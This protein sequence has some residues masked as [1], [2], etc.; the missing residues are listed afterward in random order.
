[1]EKTEQSMKDDDY[2][3][4]N[5]QLWNANT[6]IHVESSFYNVRG[7]LV[8]NNSHTLNPTELDLLGDT[9]QKCILHLQCHFGLD[10]LSLARLGAKHVT[11]VDL[12]NVAIDKA[13]KLAIKTN[14]N[15]ITEF[16][17]CDIYELEQQLPLEQDT[18][19]DIVFTSYGTT[20]WLPDLTKWARLIEQ[21]LKVGGF[22][23]IVDFH[24]I[25][26]LFDDAYGPLATHS[27]FDRGPIIENTK[28]TYA[29]PDAPIEN[30]SVEWNHTM[31]DIITA[32]IQHNLKIDVFKELDSIPYDVYPNMCRSSHDGQ[33]RFKNFH[34]KILLVY[35]IKATKITPGN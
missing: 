23:V 16:I 19:F 3:S 21:Y 28:G 31:A 25:V 2:I 1:M 15:Y 29:D 17:C 33:Y 18:L 30:K 34:G 7:F 27:Y 12:S 5:R 20:A 26:C 8:N 4:V 10:T 11:G 22:F 13:R 24:P 9:E 6:N 35:A 32:L 14:L